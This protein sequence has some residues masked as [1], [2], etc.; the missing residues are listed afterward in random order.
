MI[1]NAMMGGNPIIEG[2]WENTKTGERITV[3]DCIFEDNNMIIITNEKGSINYDQ[4]SNYV[5]ISTSILP[6][7]ST[8]QVDKFESEI[9][10]ILIQDDSVAIG[11]ELKS[12]ITTKKNENHDIIKKSIGD[13]KNI[14]IDF[15][16]KWDDDI[17]DL[18]TISRVLDINVDEI[19]DYVINNIVN[20]EVLIEKIKLSIK[21]II[22]D[23]FG[24]QQESKPHTK[25]TKSK[26]GK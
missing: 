10:K 19:I 8:S 3:R 4:F 26:N 9:N 22:E 5:Q 24:I 2:T 14:N 1:N 13:A 15:Q 17:T 21:S 7:Q 23:K 12:I 20:S 6:Q 16:V 18:K 25:N 11:N